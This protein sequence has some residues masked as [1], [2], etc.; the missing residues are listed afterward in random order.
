[1]HI[2]IPMSIRD[3]PPAPLLNDIVLAGAFALERARRTAETLN[4]EL[5][6][7]SIDGLLSLLYLASV[8]GGTNARA[9]WT[10]DKSIS[11]DFLDG[12]AKSSL[13]ANQARMSV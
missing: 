12:R 2:L 10:K 5:D 9:L 11:S 3:P 6:L 7:I 1:M 4:C 13:Q 8:R